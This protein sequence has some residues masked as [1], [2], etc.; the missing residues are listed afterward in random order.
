MNW[1]HCNVIVCYT[2][3]GAAHVLFPHHYGADVLYPAT[4]PAA[5]AA[6]TY[7]DK[8]NRGTSIHHSIPKQFDVSIVWQ[9][10]ISWHAGCGL[11]AQLSWQCYLDNKCVFSSVN[12]VDLTVKQ[13]LLFEPVRTLLLVCLLRHYIT[14]KT[15][16]IWSGFSLLLVHSSKMQCHYQTQHTVV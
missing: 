16:P 6:L 14:D 2:V 11:H 4:A 10:L 12:F 9:H 5:P 15:N 3:L 13:T 8:Y 1:H 7:V